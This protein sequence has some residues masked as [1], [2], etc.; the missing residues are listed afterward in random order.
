MND[1]SPAPDWA[2]RLTETRAK[3][4]MLAAGAEKVS[5]KARTSGKLWVFF[6]RWGKGFVWGLRIDALERN[7]A[8]EVAAEFTVRH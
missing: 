4:I 7:F 5:V 3:E 2:V 1:M 8:R 6:S